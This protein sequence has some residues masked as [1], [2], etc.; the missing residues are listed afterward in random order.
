MDENYKILIASYIKFSMGYMS[1]HFR[2]YMIH[3]VSD[4]DGNMSTNAQVIIDSFTQPSHLFS[5]KK[6]F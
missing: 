5:V 1:S 3:L 2:L 4:N 6:C